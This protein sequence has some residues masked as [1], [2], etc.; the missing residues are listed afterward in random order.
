MEAR[1]SPAMAAILADGRRRTRNLALTGAMAVLVIGAAFYYAGALDLRRYADA[2]P[3][4]LTLARDAMPPDFSRWANWGKPLL[5]TLSMSVAGTVLGAVAAPPL[6]ALA[7]RNV[8][9]R[10]W[11]GGPVRL[12]LNVLRSIPGLIWGVLYVAAVGFGPLP[13][14]LALATHSAGMLGKFYAETLEHVEPG[15]G[16]ALRSQ[17]VSRLGVLRFSVLPQI[18]PRLA[19]VTFYRW[20][21]NL[22]AATTL[23]VVGAGGL[24][25]EIITAFHLFEYR[26]AA[27]L[28]IVLLGLVIVINLAGAFVRRRFL[29]GH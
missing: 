14:I 21:H 8:V 17:G 25:L 3:T 29:D 18:L 10:M 2:I 16:D 15:P 13:G 28:I 6:G 24:G 22:R 11:I 12:F 23:G 20:E 7:A 9:R 19:D 1:L 27:A 26:E 4:I 5:E